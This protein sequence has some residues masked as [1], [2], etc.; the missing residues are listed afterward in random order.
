MQM[1]RLLVTAV[2][3]SSLLGGL[4]C[5]PGSGAELAA[6]RAELASAKAELQRSTE[7]LEQA[8][9]ELKAARET[10]EVAAQ[11]S[12]TAAMRALES[13]A[14]DGLGEGVDVAARC[15]A[16]ACKV[17]RAFIRAALADPSELMRQAR[18]VPSIKDGVS[19]GF[20]VYGIRSRSTAKLFGLRNGDLLTAVNGSSLKT[21]DEAMAAYTAHKGAEK[22]VI[23]IVRK[24]NPVSLTVELVDGG[25]VPAEEPPSSPE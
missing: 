22:F 1:D 17:D 24:G 23:S 7:Q 9:A 20:K 16:E 2:F 11:A 3:G 12:A 19:A 13:D 6:A 21:M 10:F 5:D 25:E 14:A 18:V 8:T 15:V 4:G